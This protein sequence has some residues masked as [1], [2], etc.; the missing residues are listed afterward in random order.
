LDDDNPKGGFNLY[1][2]TE[3]KRANSLELLLMLVELTI[4]AAVKC[5]RSAADNMSEF[6]VTNFGTAIAQLKGANIFI[7]D[8]S[9]CTFD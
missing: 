5:L 1:Y 7:I 4:F 3:R 6:P 8:E 2:K 9:F